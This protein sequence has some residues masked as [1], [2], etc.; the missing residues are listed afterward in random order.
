MTSLDTRPINPESP[1]EVNTWIVF[2]GRSMS[3]PS[4]GAGHL[5]AAALAQAMVER[6]DLFD[7]AAHY[8]IAENT[9]REF[10]GYGFQAGW[11]HYTCCV[12]KSIYRLQMTR[13]LDQDAAFWQES[14]QC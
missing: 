1:R 3:A 10:L 14:V 7:V 9:V 6:Q 5:F 8:A 4:G 12:G 13:P 2:A 11:V